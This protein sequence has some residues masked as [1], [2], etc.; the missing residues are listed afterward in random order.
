MIF[1]SVLPLAGFIMI[2]F[3]SASRMSRD[4]VSEYVWQESLLQAAL[5]WSAWL[6][7]SVEGLSLIRGLT[8]WG[9][10]SAWTLPALFLAGYEKTRGDIL[11]GG[12]F[13]WN[14]VKQFRPD[15]VE[16]A[17]LF[18]IFAAL[19]ILLIT[20][21]LS[22][23]NI[24]DVLTYHMSRVMH[25]A[26]NRSLAYYPTA[27][28]WQLWMP[29]FGEMWQLNL[30]LLTGGDWLSNLPQWFSLILTMAAVSGMARLLGA[31]RRGQMTAA[32]FILSLPVIVLQASGAKN[33][34][35]TGFFLS[36][37]AYY[38]LKAWL[39]SF[40]VRDWIFTGLAVGLGVLVKGNFPFFVLPLLLVLLVVSII[41]QGWKKTVLFILTGLVLVSLI[42]G[43]QWI[44][45]TGTFGSP[46][47]VGDASF[48]LNQRFGFDVTVSNL[49]RNLAVQL[50]SRYG[51]VNESVQKVLVWLHARLGMSL[52][53]PEITHGPQE[54]YYV[55]TREEVVGHP[56]HL[57]LTGLLFVVAVVFL[58][59]NRKNPR[60]RAAVF[61]G[62]AAVSGMILF[63]SIFRWQ[64]WGS[65]YFLPYYVLFAPLAGYAVRKIRVKGVSILLFA[66]LSVV[67]VNPLVN[68]YSRSFSWSEENRNSIWRMSRKG[69]LFAN[70]PEVE[71]AVLALV[72]EMEK[73][74]CRDYG[75]KFDY[76]TPEYL[77]WAT[78][79]PEI[80]AYHL[81]HIDV[82]NASGRHADEGFE[83]CGFVMMD[84]ARDAFSPGPD[85]RLASEWEVGAY[86]IVLYLHQDFYPPE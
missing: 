48:T 34:I 13:L 22:P 23:P 75:L 63:S 82:A 29:P 68:N 6:V 58:F 46:L 12:E 47:N 61:L 85:Y 21:I 42:N 51:I 59:I 2:W 28:P 80:L 32:M 65:R 52:F 5:L 27:I 4:R 71:G 17:F 76:N 31:K 39:K 79:S 37:V 44:R 70:H 67:M 25:W 57:A 56:V 35:T 64:V 33:D 11:H 38:L 7:L 24:H 53:D 50:T 19:L 66:L 69:L 10:F 74:G 49:S 41:K 30:Y 20:G 16:K 15:W 72:Y 84:T 8:F 3:I 55:P 18:V 14:K 36:V 77:I 81:E 83:P 62:L 9:I 60:S 26:Q 54:F 43:G 45:N 78:L 86:P 73:S 1:L 40:D